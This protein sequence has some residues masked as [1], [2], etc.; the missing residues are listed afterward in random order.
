MKSIKITI[1]GSNKFK[2]KVSSKKAKDI[3]ITCSEEFVA[4][5]ITLFKT[6]EK[7]VLTEH[8]VG[9]LA[10]VC[11]THKLVLDVKPVFLKRISNLQS[12]IDSI[13]HFEKTEMEGS[14]V[15]EAGKES[16]QASQ[17]LQASQAPNMVN[18]ELK[19]YS[20]Q[21]LNQT[22]SEKC[23][24]NGE[25][26]NHNESLKLSSDDNN[27]KSIIVEDMKMSPICSKNISTGVH[28]S[29][30]T[31]SLRNQTTAAKDLVTEDGQRKIM[32]LSATEDTTIS[33]SKDNDNKTTTIRETRHREVAVKTT[34][35]EQD[36]RMFVRI[37]SP[38]HRIITRYHSYS[39]EVNTS[40]V[41]ENC[42]GEAAKNLMSS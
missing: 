21:T 8:N 11:E 17:V 9:Y 37:V 4:D 2:L 36:P 15:E 7:L 39:P 27:K 32:A 31:I 20:D 34:R 35:Y 16:Q 24:T 22:I 18:Q 25:S 13:L 1:N 33:V 28:T 14:S 40:P 3:K 26:N 30:K 38:K 23:V 41:F 29:S 10:G 19:F 6:P 12:E 5:T 42:F